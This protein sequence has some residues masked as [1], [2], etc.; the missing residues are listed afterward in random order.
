MSV[1]GGYALGQR[2]TGMGIMDKANELK[3][4]AK[5]ALKHDDKI[6]K[7][8]DK[9]DDATGRKHSDKIDKGAQA[10]KDKNDKRGE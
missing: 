1:I 9:I 4:K 7:A 8:A 3:D 6:D 10:M 2:G 5:D